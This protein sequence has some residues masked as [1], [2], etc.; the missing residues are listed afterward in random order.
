MRHEGNKRI[1]GNINSTP[2]RKKNK[3]LNMNEKFFLSTETEDM[4]NYSNIYLLGIYC[5]VSHIVYCLHDFSFHNVCGMTAMECMLHIA[6]Y[7]L[8]FVDLLKNFI[9]MPAMCQ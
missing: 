3:H 8:C 9:N 1:T 5:E 6:N 4:L 2:K 7:T